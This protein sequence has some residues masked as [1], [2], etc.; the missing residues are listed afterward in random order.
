MAG[1]S[2]N[3][4]IEEKLLPLAGGTITGITMDDS[5]ETLADFGEPVYGLRVTRRDGQKVLLWFM[6]D[7]E[8]N[9]PGF[10]EIENA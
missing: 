8:G 4:Y 2:G 1:T 5:P 9:G 3:R 10:P 6:R 7:A